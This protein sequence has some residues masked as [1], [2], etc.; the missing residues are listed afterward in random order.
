MQSEA[1]QLCRALCLPKEIR[2]GR[3]LLTVETVLNGDSNSTNE[4]GGS[5]LVGRFFGLVGEI[6]VQPWLLYSWLSTKYFFPL[7]A[8]YF[9]LF[10]PI[11][12]QAGQA[13]VLGRLSLYM[14]PCVIPLFITLHLS[15]VSGVA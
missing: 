13:V 1:Q 10:L 8:H 3:P 15:C 9:N 2:K 4:R 14:C 6:F 7:S 11:V 12:Q 5:S